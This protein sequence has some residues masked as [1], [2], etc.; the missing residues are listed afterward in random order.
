MKIDDTSLLA[1]VKG[2]LPAYEYAII[3]QA[4]VSAEHSR[5]LVSTLRAS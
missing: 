1:H 2:Q 5:L 4:I 3:A